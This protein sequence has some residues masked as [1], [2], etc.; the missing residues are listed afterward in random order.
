VVYLMGLAQNQTE[1]NRVIEVA[2]TIPDVKQVVSYVKLVGQ[3]LP[4]PVGAAPGNART[5][6]ADD[7]VYPDG[8]SS[9]MSG[10]FGNSPSAPVPLVP[11]PVQQET[12]DSG[13]ASAPLTSPGYGGGF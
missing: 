5:G 1:L 9:D 10:D 6:F 4:K 12:L 11:A 13:S 2:R 3:P 8:T 7:P